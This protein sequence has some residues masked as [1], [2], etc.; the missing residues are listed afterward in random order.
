MAKYFIS[1]SA[2]DKEIVNEFLDIFEV[3]PIPEG[4]IFCTSREGDDITT[5]DDFVKAIKDELSDAKYVF[6]CFSQC[7]IDSTVCM[8]ELGAGWIKEEE[9]ETRVIPI[10]IDKNFPFDSTTPLFR[11]I[12]SVKALDKNSLIKFFEEVISPDYS[13]NYTIKLLR[14]ID[15]FLKFI[16]TEEL[17]EP[18]KV[19][20]SEYQNLKKRN[21]T[22]E[23]ENK[24]LKE[25]V[26]FYK[27]KSVKLSKAETQEKK[28][29]ILREYSSSV[30]TFEEF[31]KKIVSQMF[32]FQPC[33]RLAL[34]RHFSSCEDLLYSEANSSG[35][36]QDA[37][38]YE[39][40]VADKFSE[41]IYKLNVENDE[42]SKV[43]S[44][45]KECADLLDDDVKREIKK[46]Y[47]ISSSITN[48]RFWQSV[49]NAN[50]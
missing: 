15:K 36:L 16:D 37:L 21:N 39:Y 11:N 29:E 17:Q 48:K 27:K 42:I 50:F 28:N 32:E 40:L 35:G 44:N 38:D 19:P 1:H 10:I 26:E 34:F 31:R 20:Y 18:N 2:K 41:N 9:N 23:N 14:K 6:A 8:A 5:G 46:R 4:D 13:G 47:G 12:Q 33:V 30:D 25:E 7:Y 49:F 24:E 45:I 43:I 3:F 22:L